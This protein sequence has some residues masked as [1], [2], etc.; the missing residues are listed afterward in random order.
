ME[1]RYNEKGRL[2]SIEE[3]KAPPS[4]YAPTFAWSWNEP[5]TR[6]GIDEQLSDFHAVG[7]RSLYILPLPKD[8]RPTLMATT[9][10]PEYLSE[11]FFALVS[12][13][14]RKAKDM[15][16]ML[17]LYDEGGWPSGGACGNTYKQNPEAATEILHA[18][19]ILLPAGECYRKSEDAIAAFLGK[20]R[21]T[22]GYSANEAV[23][24]TEY[25]TE[26]TVPSANL[27]D[28]LNA[29][30]ISTFLKNT[31]EGYV[32]AV[33]DLFGDSVKLIFTDEPMQ[34]AHSVPK[35]LFDAFYKEY[36]YDLRDSLYAVLDAYSSDP[37]IHRVRIDYVRL[38]GKM[39][40]ELCFGRI[41]EW[42][43]A[44]DICFGGHL[45]LEHVPDGGARMSYFSALDCLRKFHVPGIDVIWDQIWY[46]YEETTP[47]PEGSLFFPRI[48]PSA[49]RQMG[50]NLALTE[51]GSVSSE[52]FY[53]EVLRYVIHYQAVRG[54]NVFNLM[55]LPYGR[56]NLSALVF[57]PMYC[58]EKPGFYHLTAVNEYL[59][60]LAYLTRLGEAVGDTALYHPAADFCA[61]ALHSSLATR[62]YNHE[63]AMLEDRHVWFDLI[64]DEGIRTAEE[65]EDGLALGD[66]VYKHII[67]PRCEYMPKDVKEKI[68][69]YIG[70]GAP[71]LPLHDPEIRVMIRKLGED[72]LWFFFNEKADRASDC[73]PL[74]KGKH[75]YRL[76]AYH[77]QILSCEGDTLSLSIEC[78]DMAIYL[79]TDKILPT[80]DLSPIWRKEI[81]NFTPVSMRKFSVIKGGMKSEILP[82]PE[83]LPHD[84]SADITYEVE[85]DLPEEP[86]EGEIYRLTLTDTKYYAAVHAEEETLGVFAFTPMVAFI[87]GGKLKKEMKLTVTVSNSAS[88]EIAKKRAL[89]EDYYPDHLKGPYAKRKM[90]AL[91]TRFSPPALGSL[92]I[93]KMK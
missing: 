45:N 83:F 32:K 18:R 69:K 56:N 53:P 16:M 22:D 54:I 44:H 47:V 12:Y 40:R 84:I 27:I 10:S 57:R 29:S 86:H 50:R 87:D 28:N 88:G 81:R 13:A 51:T 80:E 33:G 90:Y 42:C 60:R 79:V 72:G 91:E 63:G 21:V 62:A 74:P 23:V 68:K 39:F 58:P 26:P 25:Y 77:G 85:I 3:F 15:G 93:E 89:I 48:A 78:G 8:F 24:L 67:V 35:G 14:I 66:A 31:Y 30:V 5:I 76:D 6:E 34:L 55:A 61:S 38:L 71:L 46:P 75:A 92:I 36:G 7:I 59:S 4:E 73:V 65:T 1:Y 11:E 49:A 20:T 37:E 43:K 70:E 41:A 9:F 19:E 17:W 82:V 64:D 52:S 2:F